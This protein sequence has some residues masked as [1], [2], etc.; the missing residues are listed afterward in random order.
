VQGAAFWKLSSF[1]R[2][3][4][5]FN[6]PLDFRCDH[7]NMLTT[8]VPPAGGGAEAG[9][10]NTEVGERAAEADRLY[11][12]SHAFFPSQI[13]ISSASVKKI[14]LT[15]ACDIPASTHFAFSECEEVSR[16]SN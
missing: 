9:V 6:P 4:H 7:S 15:R 5:Y 8:V 13:S 1:C 12:T 14:A 2:F 3:H 11:R 10:L 16:V